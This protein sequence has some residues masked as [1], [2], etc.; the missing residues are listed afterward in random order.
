MGT[1]CT[2]GWIAAIA[3]GLWPFAVWNWLMGWAIFEHHT[4]PRVPWFRD[5]QE[6][7]AA[8]AQTRCTVHIVLPPAMDFLLHRI[9]Q[10]TAHHLDVTVPLYRLREAQNTVE[11]A[12]AEVIV[13]RWSPLSF[14]RHLRICRLYDY[15]RHQW[16]DFNGEPS[17][18]ISCPVPSS[19]PAVRNEALR[20]T[21]L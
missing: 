14:I 13:Y 20:G 11:T 16:L 6:W 1:A 3:A 7:R 4:H 12:T 5:E 17:S 21:F 8:Q 18:T 10:H 19:V 2:L 9:M 15:E